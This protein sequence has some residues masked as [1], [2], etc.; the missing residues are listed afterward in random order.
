MEVWDAYDAQFNRVEGVTLIRGEAIPA[1]LFHLV[2]DIIVKHTDG[3]YLLMLRDERKRFGGMWEATAG[4][5]ALQGE[6]PAECAARE[7]LEETGIAAEQLTEVGRTVSETNRSIYVEFLCVTSCEKE[8]VRLQEGETTDYQ[9][10]SRDALLRMTQQEL[11]TKRMQ[12][13]L[14]KLQG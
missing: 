10:V 9:W 13:F 6:S 14:Q 1:G 4:G 3:T 12:Q 8:S 11:V 7:L 5:S 2:C